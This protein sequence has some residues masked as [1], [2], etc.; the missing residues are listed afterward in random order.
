MR[1]MKSPF[2]ETLRSDGWAVVGLLAGL[3]ACSGTDDTV[4]NSGGA[5]GTGGPLGTGGNANSGGLSSGGVGTAGG[6]AEVGGGG[7]STTGG[8][9]G[10]SGVGGTA[11]KGGALGK[12]GSGGGAGANAGAPPSCAPG[13]LGM[14]D[15]GAGQESCCLSLAVTGVHVLPDLQEQRQRSNG[16]GGLGDPQRL[17][18][19]QVARRQFRRLLAE[20]GAHGSRWRHRPGRPR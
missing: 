11:G 18:T 1:R 15:C 9:T 14:T 7:S 13:G 19:R 20:L 6:V 4:T 17:P 16:A 3:S 10:S 12:G 2:V 5:S 8:V